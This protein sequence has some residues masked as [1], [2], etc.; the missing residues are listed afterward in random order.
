MLSVAIF[1][2]CKKDFFEIKDTNGFEV[3]GSFEDEGAVGL[4]LNRTYAL[5]MPQWP[6]IGGIHNTSDETN[7]ASTAFL[8]GTLAEN[9]ITDIGTASGITTN[10]YSDIRRCNVAIDGLNTSVTLSEGTRNT[11][12]GQFFFLRAYTYFKLVRLYG[13][14]P[15]VFHA[16]G[17]DDNNLQVPRSK[18][19]ECVAAIASDLDS[20]AAYLPATWS[21]SEAGRVTK[22]AALAVKAK[23][24]LYWASPQFNPSNIASRWTEAYTANKAAYD[25]GVANGYVLFNS[26][27]NIFITEDN[28]EVLLV[29]KYNS[30]KDLGTNLENVT[31]P[32]SET[33]AGSGSNQ[34]TWNLVQA[35]TMN[36]GMPIAAAG[37]GYNATQF[38]LNRDPRF[39]ATIAWNG[40]AWALSGKA[41]RKQWTYTGVLDETAATI[42]TG[43]YCKRLC[44]PTLSAAQAQYISNSG[45]GSGMDW[46][47]MRFAE[48]ILNLAECANE[49]GNLTEAKNMVRLIRQRAGITAGAFDYGLIFATDIPSMRS[50][51]L[52]ERQVEFAMEGMRNFDLRRTR[53]LGLITPR[54]SYK[55]AVKPP[56]YAGLTRTG[57]LPTDIFLDKPDAFGVKP[58]DTANLNNPAVYTKIFVTPGVTAS[59]EGIN[60]ISLP[61]KYYVYPLPTL[62]TQIPVIRQT[63]GWAGGTFDPYQ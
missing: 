12:K 47:E 33:T 43:F 55:V 48:V 40:D 30:S 41:T 60:A 45:G 15:L 39:A 62:F 49:T 3:V 8:Y 44:N 22:V 57:A 52:N 31:R 14:V 25:A 29:R 19:S 38:W 10:R 63:N 5:V 13:G 37:S 28:K 11:L 59:L 2:S 21:T 23:A 53:N 26:Y 34:P 54:L 27:A 32:F 36:N 20:A 1:T 7:S 51:I 18:T 9:S 42:V 58:R 35:Y 16:Q 56:Y 4:F 6:T 46:I 61:D 24:L 17:V 50:L